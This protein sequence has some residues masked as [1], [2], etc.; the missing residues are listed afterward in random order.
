[1]T[2]DSIQLLHDSFVLTVFVRTCLSSN[3]L[4]TRALQKH[5]D[6][7]RD[8]VDRGRFFFWGGS[9]DPR[10]SAQD[11]R[12]EVKVE[13]WFGYRETRSKTDLVVFDIKHEKK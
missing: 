10:K 3:G 4:A 13:G 2:N 1:M 7:I 11:R 6:W 12:L 5:W 9:L 8:L